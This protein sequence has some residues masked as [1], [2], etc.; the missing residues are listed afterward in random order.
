M[1]PQSC[2]FFAAINSMSLFHKKKT[3]QVFVSEDE[4]T[5]KKFRLN[6]SEIED[7]ATS[8]NKI[9]KMNQYLIDFLTN[10]NQM[11]QSDYVPKKF[12]LGLKQLIKTVVQSRKESVLYES[13]EY[14]YHKMCELFYQVTYHLVEFERNSYMKFADFSKNTLFP[15]VVEIQKTLN[16]CKSFYQ[17][18]F[19]QKISITKKEQF[20]DDERRDLLFRFC[21]EY[22]IGLEPQNISIEKEKFKISDLLFICSNIFIRS[23][24]ILDRNP[25][26]FL[27]NFISSKFPI[28]KQFRN[29]LFL[30]AKLLGL[31]LK[32]RIKISLYLAQNHINLE[33]FLYDQQL[34]QPIFDI[35]NYVADNIGIERIYV[36]DEIS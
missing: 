6:D 28:S 10:A 31:A 25:K 3:Y 9:F 27:K 32:L 12:M 19:L 20:T 35:V 17:K 15:I 36:V 24:F 34:I 2:L 14:E 29:L 5:I 26:T 1:N 33:K 22:L 21:M 11:I 16:T 8:F 4:T 30:N 13:S 23:Y 18:N 7:F